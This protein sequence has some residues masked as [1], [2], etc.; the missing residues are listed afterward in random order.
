MIW[1]SGGIYRDGAGRSG[2]SWGS[3]LPGSSGAVGTLENHA[4]I[5]PRYGVLP[6]SAFALQ[7][8]GDCA[9]QGL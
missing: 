6:Q 7:S 1:N 9:L 2:P 5:S 8:L 3:E 4:A